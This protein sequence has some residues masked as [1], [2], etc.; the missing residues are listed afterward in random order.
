MLRRFSEFVLLKKGLLALQQQQLKAAQH[1]PHTH[2]HPHHR[3]THSGGAGGPSSAPRPPRTSSGH[4]SPTATSA[5][6]AAAATPQ[7]LPQAQGWASPPP[8]ASLTPRSSA[9]GWA[10]AGDPLAAVAEH[11]DLLRPAA[12][13]HGDGDG[14]GASTSVL[15]VPD[16]WDEVSQGRGVLG[17]ARLSGE[18]VAHREA[19]LS[20]CM[21]QLLALNPQPWPLA[22]HDLLASRFLLAP[23]AADGVNAPPP[24]PRAASSSSAGN[25]QGGDGAP[26]PG[27]QGVQAALSRSVGS[28]RPAAAAVAS[29]RPPQRSGGGGTAPA[30]GSG[31]SSEPGDGLSS[32]SAAAASAV[33][34]QPAA[35]TVAPPRELSMTVRLVLE[36]PPGAEVPDAELLRRQ[37][38][39]CAGCKAPLARGL[40]HAGAEGAAGAPA[41]RSAWRLVGGGSAGA[42]AGAAPQTRRC[43][44]CPL[45]GRAVACVPSSG[46]TNLWLCT[47]ARRCW[48]TGRVYCGACHRGDSSFIPA[49]VL[50]QWDLTPRPVCSAAAEYLA[51]VKDQPLL[52]VPAIN[53]GLYTRCVS[54][55]V[56]GRG[57]RCRGS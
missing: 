53:P 28:L 11:P 57:A 41:G 1:A 51:A 9:G 18:T 26:P 35:A 12:P 2:A 32:S 27:P 38:G 47:C 14:G 13:P 17:R 50:H 37:G 6:P 29:P 45:A 43:G 31:G 4:A 42:G 19:L 56:G 48:Y 5:A 33:G 49:L 8:S 55:R 44:R 24:P 20:K 23:P 46:A 34:G 21:A 22:L 52:C 40:G 3:R 16:C 30:P 39:A 7:R 36:P 15:A 25:L 10:G 54:G